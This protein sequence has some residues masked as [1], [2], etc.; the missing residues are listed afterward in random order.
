[1]HVRDPRKCLDHSTR[2]GQGECPF[3]EGRRSRVLGRRYLNFGP[4][5][6]IANQREIFGIGRKG[7]VDQGKRR[8]QFKG[9]GI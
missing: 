3:N 8:R 5:Q 6:E 1:M 7:T 4:G 2:K 9:F